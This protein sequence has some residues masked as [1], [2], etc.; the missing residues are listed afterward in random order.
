V[1]GPYARI[2]DDSRSR[3]DVVGQRMNMGEALR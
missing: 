1:T 2:A 3:G